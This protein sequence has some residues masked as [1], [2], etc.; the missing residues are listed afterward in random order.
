M[1]LVLRPQERGSPHVLLLKRQTVEGDPW[2]GQISLPGGRS[3]VGET[4]LQTARREVVEETGIDIEGCELVGAMDA[5][6]PGNFSIKVKPFVVIAPRDIEVKIDND[7]FVDYFWVELSYFSEKKNSTTYTFSRQGRTIEA[8]S[9]LVLGKY[10]VWG[11]T[12]RIIENLLS[13]LK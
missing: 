1:S 2:S 3:R 13:E 9:F 10:V 8:P 12:L 5:V 7:E 6:Y 11:M 4:L